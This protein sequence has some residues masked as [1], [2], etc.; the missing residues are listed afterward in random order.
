MVFR[1]QADG[2]NDED[3]G[4][5]PPARQTMLV[6]MVIVVAVDAA[7]TKVGEGAMTSLL[8][9]TTLKGGVTALSAPFNIC[10]G[11]V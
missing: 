7:A 4:A 11:D 3:S 2:G 5:A 8:E 1:R 9:G 6:G 10:L